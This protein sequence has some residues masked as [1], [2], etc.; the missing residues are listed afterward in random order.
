MGRRPGRL[1]S[2][3]ADAFLGR[4]LRALAF[5]AASIR[6]KKVFLINSLRV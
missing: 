6:G 1:H 4:K 2:V 5:A 3:L